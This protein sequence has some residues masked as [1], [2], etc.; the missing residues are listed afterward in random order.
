MASCQHFSYAAWIVV[1]AF[2]T[3]LEIQVITGQT[4]RPF[5]FRKTPEPPS[6]DY[7]YSHVCYDFDTASI[8][9]VY[10]TILLAGLSDLDSVSRPPLAHPTPDCTLSTSQ[11]A[12]RRL[13]FP[14]P[15]SACL[16][17]R[18][19][20]GGACLPLPAAVV[21]LACFPA[22]LSN[23][24]RA[25]FCLSPLQYIDDQLLASGF[26]VSTG[27]TIFRNVSIN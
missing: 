23:K 12:H 4:Q 15:P 1:Y 27:H 8:P 25:T 11:A 19:V 22:L 26:C 14:N 6:Q 24:R 3:A 7:K 20:I 21:R 17:N 13:L 16:G 10:S 9:V 5:F 18:Y 2:Y